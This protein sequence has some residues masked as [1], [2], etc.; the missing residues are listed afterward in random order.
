MEKITTFIYKNKYKYQLKP[1][2]YSLHVSSTHTIF[3]EYKSSP[4]FI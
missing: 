2:G 4:N 3:C 1:I